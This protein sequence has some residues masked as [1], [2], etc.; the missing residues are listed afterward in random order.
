METYILFVQHP[1][2]KPTVNS[3]QSRILKVT[4]W[5]FLI[6]RK[7]KGEKSFFHLSSIKIE[8]IISAGIVYTKYIFVCT[9][10]SIH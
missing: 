1:G 3:G 2:T 10:I 4:A 8:R 6:L 7:K 5:N 9:D